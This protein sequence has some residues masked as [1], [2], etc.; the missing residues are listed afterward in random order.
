MKKFMLSIDRDGMENEI[1]ISEADLG[2]GNLV[3]LII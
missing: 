3:G 1:Q 2:A